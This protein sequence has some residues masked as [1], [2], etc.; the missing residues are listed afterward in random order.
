MNTKKSIEVL[1]TFISINDNRFKSYE[2]ASKQTDESDLISLFIKF[3][4]KSKKRKAE[5][6]SEVQ[7]LGGKPVKDSS[8]TSPFLKFWIK[9]KSKFKVKDRE[10]IL[11]CCEYE[12]DLIQ[13]KFEKVLI[14]NIEYLTPK[15]QNMLQAQY[16]SIKKDHDILKG[17]GDLLVTCRR[18]NLDS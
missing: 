6:I 11:N 2:K 1:N 15:H 8:I 9:L 4:E 13:K 5:L 18:F 17:L 14:T 10:E 12:A 16:Q 3:Q 7:K